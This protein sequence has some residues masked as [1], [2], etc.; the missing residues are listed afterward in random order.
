MVIGQ[1]ELKNGVYHFASF[2]ASASAA[3]IDPFLLHQRL[4]PLPPRTR[5]LPSH[6][7]DYVLN[8]ATVDTLL[9]SSSGSILSGTRFPITNYVHYDKLHDRYRG[10]LGAIDASPVPKN[11]KEAVQYASWRAGYGTGV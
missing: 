7:S 6:L 4:V 9:S 3:Q 1:G 11:F 5:R 10:F 8:S 2:P